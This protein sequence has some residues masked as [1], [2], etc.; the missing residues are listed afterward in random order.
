[1]TPKDLSRDAIVTLR[2]GNTTDFISIVNSILDTSSKKVVASYMNVQEDT[3]GLEDK[4]VNEITEEDLANNFDEYEEIVLDFAEGS[5]T[6]SEEMLQK[7][8]T[9]YHKLN[10]E[11]KKTFLEDLNSDSINVAEKVITFCT[12]VKEV[13]DIE[14]V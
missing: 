7:I 6:V 14:V 4:A 1:M 10:D 12:E 11:N 3:D 8:A 5:L 2:N 9:V 13:E